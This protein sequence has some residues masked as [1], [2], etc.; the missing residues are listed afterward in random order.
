LTIAN[1]QGSGYGGQ[2]A[3]YNSAAGATNPAKYFRLSP[4]GSIEIINNAFSVVLFQFTESGALALTDRIYVN[5][6]TFLA[7]DPTFHYLYDKS[8]NAA[9]LMGGTADPE[10][11]YQNTTHRFRGIAG[12]N[13]DYTINSTGIILQNNTAFRGKKTDNTIIALA[14]VATSNNIHIG[15]EGA[16]NCYIGNGGSYFATDGNFYPAGVIILKNNSYLYATNAAGT[17]NY[18]VIGVAS[19]NRI[20]INSGNAYNVDAYGTWSH[21]GTVFNTASSTSTGAFHMAPNPSGTAY[22]SFW[23]N[24]GTTTYLLLTNNNDALGTYNGLRPFYVTNASGLISMGHGLN[25]TGTLT[26]ASGGNLNLA[27]GVLQLAGVNFAAQDANYNYLYDKSSRGAMLMGGSSVDTTYYRNSVHNFQGLAGTGA[28]SVQVAGA[29]YSTGSNAIFIFYD[30]STSAQWAWYATGNYTRLYNGSVGDL[31]LFDNVGNMFFKNNMGVFG[32]DTAG[33]DRRL[34]YRTND[35]CMVN[36]Q[37]TSHCNI[38]AYTG[39]NVN[40]YG[41]ALVA[42]M[43][44][45]KPGGGVW[46]DSSDV[47]LKQGIEDYTTSLDAILKLRPVSFEFNGLA[48]TVTGTRYIGL[49]ADEVEAVM[50]EMV[51]SWKRKLHPEDEHEVDVK[52]LDT[53]ALTFALINAVKLLAAKVSALEG[54]V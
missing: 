17:L 7:Q 36:D 27:A 18:P 12:A 26:I 34:I 41:A 30:R 3:M 23:Y 28:T 43:T 1:D 40:L 35:V 20:K 6:V 22:G 37:A 48:E 5:G 44:C 39:Y 25:L 46:L 10:I 2:F 49:I 29:V 42:N 33:T 21:S 53:T 4:V 54:R 16:T 45:Y 14:Y 50:P 31:I 47:R 38:Y 52:T 8:G 32:K 15:V 9:I 51:G 11:Y 24:D 13:Y 19:D